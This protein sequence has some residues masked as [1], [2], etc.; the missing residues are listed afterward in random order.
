MQHIVGRLPYDY[1]LLFSG[2]LPEYVYKV[3]GLD[4][5]YPFA[6]LRQFGH[7]TGRARLADRSAQFS[8]EIRRSIPALE[9][10]SE[11]GR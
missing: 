1:R 10:D 2:Y 6:Q 8:Q 5:R 11:T 4:R 7:I 3:G 9:S